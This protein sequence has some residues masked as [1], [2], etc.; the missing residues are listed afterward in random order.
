MSS[1]RHFGKWVPA[2]RPVVWVKHKTSVQL[3]CSSKTMFR[4]SVEWPALYW[5]WY[6]RTMYSP[7][8]TTRCI[9]RCWTWYRHWWCL[10]LH[11]MA[12]S[13]VNYR[14][15]KPDRRRHSLSLL[16]PNNMGVLLRL[17]LCSWHMKQYSFH[18]YILECGTGITKKRFTTA[19]MPRFSSHSDHVWKSV[20]ELESRAVTWINFNTTMDK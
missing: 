5:N 16:G 13:Q 3:F 12:P 1:V 10:S 19:E 7:S 4:H 2:G 11:A 17:C 8:N 14:L 6:Q 20:N 15:R 9:I 18:V